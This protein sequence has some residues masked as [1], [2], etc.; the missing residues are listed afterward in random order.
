MSRNSVSRSTLNDRALRGVDDHA[1]QP[2]RIEHAFLLIE[3]PRPVLLRHQP[4]LQP[5][6]E[7]RHRALQRCQLLVEKAAQP[8]QLVRVAEI[9]RLDHLVEAVGE[10]RDRRNRHPR[11]RSR[12]AAGGAPRRLPWPRCHHRRSVR[13][14]PLRLPSPPSRPRRRRPHCPANSRLASLSDSSPPSPSSPPSCGSDSSLSTVLRLAVAAE[15][16]AHLERGDDVAHDVT[17][18]GLILDALRQALE[19][20]ARLLLDP[21]PPQIGD[22]LAAVRRRPGRSVARASPAPPHLPAALRNAA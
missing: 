6:G 12:A 5:I 13:R 17:E 8:R 7:A 4:A 11:R 20:G 19:V 21:R 3:I 15:F 1:R 18:G 14:R 22:G 10:G 2:C 9:L 16:V